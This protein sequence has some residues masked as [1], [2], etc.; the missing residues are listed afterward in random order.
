MDIFI[1]LLISH[2]DS[3][4]KIECFQGFIHKG[5]TLSFSRVFDQIWALV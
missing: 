3:E 5:I 1:F 2:I 4:E